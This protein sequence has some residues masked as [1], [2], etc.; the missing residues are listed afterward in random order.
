MSQEIKKSRLFLVL[1]DQLFPK[2]YFR[3]HSGDCQFFMAEDYGLCTH[4]KYHKHKLI[5]F[6]TAMRNWYDEGIK[7]GFNISYTN[8]SLE[9]KTQSYFQTLEQ[10]IDH[11]PGFKSLEIYEVD[12][13]FFEQA[14]R[15]FAAQ[16]NLNL[17]FHSSPKFLYSREDFQEYLGRV[18]KP[19]LKTYYEGQRKAHSILVDEAKQPYGGKW[20]FDED[21]RKKLPARHNGPLPL[22][23][24]GTENLKEI[25]KLVDTLFPNHPGKVQTFNWATNRQQASEVLNHFLEDKFENFGPFEDA[26]E[27]DEVFLYHSTLSPYLNMGLI[28]PQEVLE[29]VLQ[30]AEERNIHYPSLEGFVRQLMGWREFIRGM[31]QN[32]DFQQNFFGFRRKMKDCWYTGKTGIPPLDDSIQKLNHHAYTHH[33]E[34]LMIQGNL[35]LL[36]E[37]DPQEVY[38]WFME[39]YIDSADWVMGPNVMGMSQ[40]AVGGLFATK[41]Y[42]AGSNYLRKMSHYPKGDWCDIMDGLYWRFIER[43]R[44]TFAKNHRM[45][46]MLATLNKMNPE[47]KERIFTAAENWI[48]SVSFD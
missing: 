4:F 26:F 21:N 18:K 38:R 33:I 2:E 40:F 27:A 32:F 42:I 31:D 24:L 6:L 17:H 10:Y 15:D 41:P 44:E 37:L 39:M 34:R 36:C 43:Q 46:M 28:T 45:G 3:T 11:N 30:F 35:M 8:L 20:S 14:L 29:A 22:A 7:E 13:R 25:Q 47:R 23:F 16:K 19:F 1:G 48:E 12:D 9:S 5:L